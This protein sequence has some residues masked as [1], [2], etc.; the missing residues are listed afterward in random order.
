MLFFCEL[1]AQEFYRIFD[2]PRKD[3]S[4]VLRNLAQP[5]T[6]IQTSGIVTLKL[7]DDDNFLKVFIQDK[8]GD[9]NI[10]TS[11]AIFLKILPNQPFINECYQVTVQGKLEFDGE[12]AFLDSVQ[13]IDVQSET[14]EIAAQN[15]V[16]PDDF[17]NYSA[18]EGMTLNFAQTLVVTS[19]SQWQR[20][21]QLTLSSLRLPSPTDVVLPGSVDYQNMII[22]NDANKIFLDDGSSQS[23]P[24]PLPFADAEGTR[25]TGSRV[26]NLIAVL[27]HESSGWFL[28]PVNTAPPVFYGNSRPLM[29]D[30]PEYHNIKVCSFNLEYYIESGFNPN[31][32]PDNQQQAD[33]QHNKI[34]KALTAIDADIYGLVEIQT[35]QAALAKIANALN[36]QAGTTSR[37][38]YVNDGTATNG[39]YTKAGFI[40]RTD[41]VVPVGSV[42]I[43]NTGV[44]NRKSTQ[45]F[46]LLSNGEKFIFSLNHFK[47]KSGSGTG[48]NADQGDGQGSYNADRVTE[49]NSI[50][51]AIPSYVSHFDDPDVLIM[52]DL[53]AYRQED[54][55]RLFY[56]NGFTNLLADTSYSYSYNGTVGCLDHALANSTMAQQVIGTT[57]FHINADEPSMFEYDKS[58]VQNN[59]YRCSDHDAVMVVMALG[60]YTHNPVSDNNKLKVIVENNVIRVLNAKNQWLTMLDVNGKQLLRCFIK[61]DEQSIDFSNQPLPNGVYILFFDDMKSSKGKRV[62][63]VM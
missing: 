11:D 13:I 4:L 56:S 61:N 51:T 62:K 46:K 33:I 58:A 21:G 26:N 8:F 37:Y 31:F 52:G 60:D 63:I 20:Y 17:S 42:K 44:W 40:Y 48:G 57:V 3:N 23:Y 30:V 9:N 24:N 7:N 18:Y 55:L 54:P 36:A 27:H 10:N 19:N 50:L 14:V 49:V 45:G 53:N 39:T 1:S 2:I 29:P 22:K 6:Q 47:A 59:M 35:G 41:R 16:F 12:I 38:A 15:V 43:N 25:R 32:G 5:K 28:Y 34:M